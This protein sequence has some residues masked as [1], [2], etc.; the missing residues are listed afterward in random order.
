M[1]RTLVSLIIVGLALILFASS[2]VLMSKAKGEGT[3]VAQAPGS[4]CTRLTFGPREKKKPTKE[5][6]ATVTAMPGTRCMRL[7]SGGKPGTILPNTPPKVGL[8]TSTAY[9]ATNADAQVKLKAIA[10]DAEGDNVLYTYTATGGR[11]TGDG[12][13]AAWNLNGVTR[14]ATY[15]ISV[16][17]DDGCGCISFD[18]AAVTL[19]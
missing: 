10:C 19:E 14:P 5:T 4:R 18:S 15:T 16:E 17:V 13:S 6:A 3:V 8:A 7:S 12:E 1:R 11:I 2:S 9:I